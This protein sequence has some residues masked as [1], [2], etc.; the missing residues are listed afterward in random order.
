MVNFK[1]LF[2]GVLLGLAVTFGLTRT[3][4]QANDDK[5]DWENPNMFDQ[6]KEE[7]H[8][9]LMPFKDVQSA[10]TKKSNQSIYYKSL[11]GTWKFNWVKKPSDRPVE[12]YHPDYDVSN[13]DNTPVPSNWEVQGYGI[14]I[15][16]NIPYP[17]ADKRYPFT[18]LREGPEPPRMPRDYNPVGS[19]RRTFTVP[20]NWDGRQI[21]IQFG[22]VKSAMYIWVNG[23]KVGYSQGSK[24]P[25]EWDIT[26]YLKKGENVLAVEVYRWCDGSYLECQDFW[27]ISGIERDVYIY[28]TPKV[29]IHDFFVHTDLDEQYKD[30]TLS[31]D[32]NL[33][34]HVNKLRS[35][36]Y[37]VEMQL[38]NAAGELVK[39]E[40]AKA[41]INNKAKADV[42]LTSQ[43]SNPLKW[44]AETPNLYKLV[45]VLKDKKGTA[46]EVIS[47]QVGFR[48]IEI[49]DTVFHINGVAVLI[50]GVNRHEHDQFTGHVIS[51][52][53]MIKEISLMKQFNI[54]AVRTCH[55]PNDERFYELCNKYGLYVTN[56][57]NIESHG[58]G[59]GEKSL[60]KKPL[61]EKAHLDRNIR[62]VERDKNH[63][64]VIV[65]S[66]GN[67]AG[68]GV[69]FTAVYKWI[70]A[71]DPSRPIHYE[72]AIMGDNTDIF[73]PQ[74]PGVGSL[75][76][77]ASKR[78]TKTMIMSEYSHAMGN[79]SG[80]LAD[81][82]DVIHDEKNEQLQGGYI[83]DWI[84]QALV[85][86][87][88]DGTT[89]W[90]YGGDYGPLGTPSD[91]NFLVNGLISADYTP[92]PSM[93]EVKYAYQYIR[94]YNENADQGKVLVK[95]YFDFIDLKDYQI[96]WNVTANGKEVLSGVAENFNVAA[97]GSKVLNIDLSGLNKKPGVEYF[98]NFTATLKKAQ[99]F[100][101]KGFVVANEQIA[102]TNDKAAVAETNNTP[103][104]ELNTTDFDYTIQGENFAIKFDRTSGKLTS[105]EI[106]G[107][108]LMQNGP[109]VNFWRAPNDNDKGSNMIG[110]LEIWRTASNQVKTT[111]VSASQLSA[112][113]VQVEVALALDTITSTQ[114][115]KYL[116]DGAG[117]VTVTTAL[118]TGSKELPDMPRFGMRLE[119][120]VNFDN[121]SWFGR[122]PHENYIDRNRSAFVGIYDGKVADQYF[123]YV[124]PQENGY[125]TDARWFELRSQNGYGI[126]FSGAPTV[127]F[128]ALHNPIEDFDQVTHS[129]FRHTNDIVKKDGVFV[130]VD[131]RMMGVA[132]DNS[133]GARPYKKYS[134]P[135]KDYEFSFS[136]EPIF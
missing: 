88:K 103:T 136:I 127:G 2:T 95:N 68:D 109:V 23:H 40:S 80:N 48:E 99:P 94:F 12:F 72:R 85:K 126:R 73:C 106:N 130:T 29:R 120:P 79:S 116:V 98:L 49:I 134:I 135:A 52:E 74:Y 55:Y 81:L 33:K 78:Q 118:K 15:Y 66:M 113:Q 53:A 51:E 41:A 35:G 60:A 64:S 50:K 107:F 86:E 97:H 36:D 121:L 125:K 38:Y 63:P 122:G 26:K 70:K 14:P 114:T 61:W 19:Y 104:I 93:W 8:A 56:E 76:K 3:E 131:Y 117:K 5:P 129:D 124:R 22:A 101:E 34:N 128:S 45:V 69:N 31:V 11:N 91:N 7:P 112:N 123:N 13:W 115:V 9:T 43:I 20:E 57:A 44:T 132:G 37:Q 119:L 58:M 27:R 96:N 75:L 10:L 1:N 89:Y 71:F 47:T 54:N 6:N 108:E 105:Y 77:Y 62:M 102:L 42:T 110:R 39:T 100:L 30:A 21:F 17:F 67:E 82:W 28:S 18:E 32:V 65:W 111:N 16:V 24:T 87:D 92:H 83:W 46:Q 25:A 59:Y 90:A 4:A 84:D 133:W